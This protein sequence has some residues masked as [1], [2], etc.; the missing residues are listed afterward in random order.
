MI[1]VRETSCFM[2]L[3]WTGRGLSGLLK[4][5]PM[6]HDD[7]GDGDGEGGWGGHECEVCMLV[8]QRWLDSVDDDE[9][10]KKRVSRTKLE[11]LV[12]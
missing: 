10:G 3:S 7:D 6:G 11:E 4:L 9:G 2:R 12:W 8:L 1:C 5:L